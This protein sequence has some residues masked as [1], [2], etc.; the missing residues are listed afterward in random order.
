M[1]EGFRRG[2]VVRVFGP[3]WPIKDQFYGESLM[4]YGYAR[5]QTAEIVEL[6]PKE[7]PAQFPFRT[8]Y[9]NEHLPWYQ[10]QPGQAAAAASPST[11]SS[12]KS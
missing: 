5:L 11:W 8:D 4:G 7:Y 1:L 3:G 2:R 10:L 6:T 9:G 12:A